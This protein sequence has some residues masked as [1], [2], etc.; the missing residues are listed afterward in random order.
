MDHLGLVGDRS[1]G[2]LARRAATDA[3]RAQTLTLPAVSCSGCCP[4]VLAV[5][6][7]CLMRMFVTACIQLCPGRRFQT[8]IQLL[9]AAL[10]ATALSAASTGL[11]SSC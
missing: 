5:P 4:L 11:S 1:V 6:L 2:P 7:G 3:E 8:G 10:S 9:D